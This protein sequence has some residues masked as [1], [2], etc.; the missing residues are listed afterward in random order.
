MATPLERWVDDVAHMTRPEKVMW[1]DGSEAE[2]QGLVEHM[3][4]DGTLLPLN[5]R[6]YP[7]CYLHRSHPSDV[8]RT[9]HLT[10]I[11]TPEREDAGPTNNW[12]APQEARDK[13]G[14]LF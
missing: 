8:A 9:E 3:L 13:V 4:G 11:C 1:C 6:T 14:K 2:Y 5:Q 10:F 12:M 7:D